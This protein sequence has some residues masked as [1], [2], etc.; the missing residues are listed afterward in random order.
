MNNFLFDKKYF[1]SLQIIFNEIVLCFL[2]GI[3]LFPSSIIFF[4]WKMTKW[5]TFPFQ[6]I[7]GLI[8][9][10]VN[11][12]VFYFKA[13]KLCQ[14][15]KWTFSLNNS[16]QRRNELDGENERIIKCIEFKHLSSY[17]FV[18]CSVVQLF[19]YFSVN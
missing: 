13:C 4:S 9:I 16:K 17:F 7:L 6:R 3:F 2:N 11:F 10:I 5:C 15:E 1:F 8:I 19:S 12:E 18:G 14:T